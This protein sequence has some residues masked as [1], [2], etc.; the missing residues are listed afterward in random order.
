MRRRQW[1]KTLFAHVGDGKRVS[2]SWVW[3][4]GTTRTAH[5]H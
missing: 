3:E 1:V 2:P 4:T 5:Y